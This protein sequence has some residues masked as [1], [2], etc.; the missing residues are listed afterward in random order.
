M[1]WCVMVWKFPFP[2]IVC[3]YERWHEKKKQT[4]AVDHNTFF[5]VFTPFSF[6]K[7]YINVKE[8][9]HNFGFNLEISSKNNLNVALI[10]F[11]SD[12]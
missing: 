4:I 10:L 2:D 3:M 11:H 1:S 12:K 9:S 7:V 8:L 6:V 5:Y